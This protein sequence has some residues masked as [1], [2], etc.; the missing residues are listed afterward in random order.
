MIPL[1]T[2]SQDQ[3]TKL[4]RF[5]ESLLWDQRIPSSVADDASKGKAGLEILRTKGFCKLDDG[6]EYVV[7]GV[8]DIFEMKEVPPSSATSANGSDM[9]GKLVFI[10]RG[11]GEELQTA[12]NTF[13]GI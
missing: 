5:L 13:V 2:L 11:V 10:G 4:E 9:G 8:T 1:P 12:F 6:R 3:H 7:Q